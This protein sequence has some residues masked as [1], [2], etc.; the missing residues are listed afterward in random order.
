[1]KTFY[2]LP[3]LDLLRYY[4]KMRRKIGPNPKKVYYADSESEAR[5]QFKRQLII[6]GLPASAAEDVAESASCEDYSDVDM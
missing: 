5:A 3:D 1:M 4:S 6:W 2:I